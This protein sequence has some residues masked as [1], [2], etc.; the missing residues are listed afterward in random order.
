VLPIHILRRCSFILKLWIFL[1]LT[2]FP[3]FG[4]D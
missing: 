4:W 3:W 2:C 1:W